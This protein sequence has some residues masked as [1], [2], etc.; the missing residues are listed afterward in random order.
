MDA[1]TGLEREGEMAVVTPVGWG[2]PGSPRHFSTCWSQ[3]DSHRWLSQGWNQPLAQRCLERPQVTATGPLL[4][5]HLTPCAFHLKKLPPDM[6][7]H[8]MTVVSGSFCS[9]AFWDGQ[10]HG[11]ESP[12][13]FCGNEVFPDFSHQAWNC[14][15]WP[16]RPATP[17]DIAQY[18]LG[19]PSLSDSKYDHE[20]LLHLAAVRRALLEQRHPET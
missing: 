16:D 8:A 5:V 3:K 18:H 11:H 10:H 4:G 14:P 17:E 6:L 13:W 20:V 15:F 7:P 12:C 9:Q 2:F 1:G 19:W